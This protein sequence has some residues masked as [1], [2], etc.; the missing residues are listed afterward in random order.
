MERERDALMQRTRDALSPT[1]HR[2]PPMRCCSHLISASRL[3][4]LHSPS[5]RCRRW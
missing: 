1:A 4:Y 5:I 3:A 2:P